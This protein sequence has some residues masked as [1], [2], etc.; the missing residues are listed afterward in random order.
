MKFIQGDAQEIE[1]IFDEERFDGILNVEAGFHYP[2]RKRFYDQCR[3]ILNPGGKLVLCDIIPKEN[4]LDDDDCKFAETYSGIIG[5]STENMSIGILTWKMQLL[6]VFNGKVDFHE[7][8]GSTFE[9]F[10]IWCEESRVRAGR[11]CF[12]RCCEKEFLRD[13]ARYHMEEPKPFRY[14]IAICTA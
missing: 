4:L 5:L 11:S 14:M 2:D 1:S 9:P 6:E 8:T 12:Q 10:Y 3:E 7:I 13:L